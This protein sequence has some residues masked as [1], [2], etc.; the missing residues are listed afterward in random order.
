MKGLKSTLI[1]AVLC[2][3]SSCSTN[4]TTKEKIDLLEDK[5][6][7]NK[8][9]SID[10]SNATK[11][12]NAYIE[13]ADN[14]TGDTLSAEYLFKAGEVAMGLSESE[15]SISCYNR[16]HTEYPNYKKAPT[17]MF[18]EGFVYETQLK[19]L[20]AAQKIYLDFIKKFPDH[21]LVDDAQFSLKNLGKSD[22]E[23]I[24]EFEAKQAELEKQASVN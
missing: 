15:K 19:T 2:V 11:L 22:E 5:L 23:I 20:A 24:K 4:Q 7:S 12:I 8:N 6:Y 9:E 1:I 14:N 16:V 13:F 3:A 18:L 21:N 10:K 17:A